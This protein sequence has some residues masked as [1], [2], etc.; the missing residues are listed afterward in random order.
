MRSLPSTLISEATSTSRSYASISMSLS[1]KFCAASLCLSCSD[2]D[3]R[4]PTMILAWI[5]L[6]LMR[7]LMGIARL[8]LTSL[9]ARIS[10]SQKY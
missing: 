6:Y 10:E 2:R 8:L 3:D 7:L 5:D 4:L 1:R 9:T